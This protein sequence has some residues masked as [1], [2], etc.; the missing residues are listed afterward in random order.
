MGQQGNDLDNELPL[1]RYGACTIIVVLMCSLNIIK[2]KDNE[3]M[4][5]LS[6]LP[7]YSVKD[8]LQFLLDKYYKVFGPSRGA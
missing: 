1:S 8:T 4:I 7:Y 2:K 3:Y 6:T 5:I